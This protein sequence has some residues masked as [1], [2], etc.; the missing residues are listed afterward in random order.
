MN[1][2]KMKLQRGSNA[3]LPAVSGSALR[4]VWREL[5]LCERKLWSELYDQTKTMVNR[6]VERFGGTLTTYQ[7]AAAEA[8]VDEF[9][10]NMEVEWKSRGAAIR[11]DLHTTCTRCDAVV[12][13][14]VSPNLSIS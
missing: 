6:L 14:K 8:E 4:Q 11:W 9:I 3:P 7:L 1:Y 13:R 10:A 2:M 12:L 5:T